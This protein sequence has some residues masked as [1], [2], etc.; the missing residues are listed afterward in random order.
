MKR[1]TVILCAAAAVVLLA[2][3]AAGSKG[4]FR[5]PA[6]FMN[7]LQNKVTQKYHE[8]TKTEPQLQEEIIQ[9]ADHHKVLLD[10]PKGYS[11]SLPEDM[12][13]DLSIAPEQIKAYRDGTTVVLTR[14]WAPYEDVFYMID[15]YLNQY[16][17]MRNT[18]R[19][20]ALPFHKTKSLPPPQAH[21]HS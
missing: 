6:Y 4:F 5:D 12:S 17:L 10:H 21:G 9:T 8:I 1:K 13:F 3:A 18:R 16:Y 19:Q 15:N 7:R 14:E 11:V 2:A 20:T